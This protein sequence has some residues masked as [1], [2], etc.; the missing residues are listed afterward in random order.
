M[1][2]KSVSSEI[3]K[4]IREHKKNVACMTKTKLIEALNLRKL[5]VELVAFYK[6]ILIKDS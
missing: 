1:C 4:K 3:A 6:F 2:E 5:D